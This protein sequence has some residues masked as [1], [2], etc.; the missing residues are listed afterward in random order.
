MIF[1]RFW[2]FEPHFLINFFLIKKTRVCYV[3]SRSVI[4]RTSS[5]FKYDHQHFGPFGVKVKM[6]SITGLAGLVPACIVLSFALSAC[7][8]YHLK[9]SCY[10]PEF[11]EDVPEV[12]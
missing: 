10:R 11:D 6:G 7:A 8:H 4:T 3:L 2:P 9:G 5:S 1:L 12:M